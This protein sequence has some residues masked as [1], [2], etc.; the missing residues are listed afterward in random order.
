MLSLKEKSVVPTLEEKGWILKGDL[1]I[2]AE[3]ALIDHARDGLIELPDNI[4]KAINKGIVP[5]DGDIG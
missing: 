4:R 1:E 5:T 3:Q 2:A